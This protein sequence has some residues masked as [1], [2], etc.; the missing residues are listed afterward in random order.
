MNVRTYQ[1]GDEVAQ[2]R[3]YNEAAGAL[4]KFKPASV[5]EVRRR[6]RGAD[7]D[8]ATRFYAIAA[9][10][11]VAYATF[12]GNGRISFPWCLPDHTSLA[13]PLLD[14][15][16]DAMRK[17]GLR[18]AWAAYR[19]DWPAQRD[20]FQARGFA[21]VREMVNYVM[22]IAEMPTPAAR[23]S[24]NIAPL[25]SA[26]L[27][28]VLQLG[29]G[30]LRVGDAAELEKCLF[31]NPYFPPESLFCV[32][33]RVGG[34]PVAVGILVIRAEYANPHQVDAAMPCFRL[35]AFGT[36]NLTHKRIKGLF[37]FLAADTRELSA[38][39]L[40]LLAHA[41]NLVHDV[42]IETFAAQVPSDAPHLN[43]FC[44]SVFRRQGG[45]PIFEREL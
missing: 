40:D 20:F 3:I 10:R 12:Q 36:E 23:T 6:M 30:V 17:S 38:F 45:F 28:V 33:S 13:S 9:G 15:V 5:D 24:S 31:H 25:T 14:H 26:D 43:R 8:P 11:P 19:A 16:L 44:Q 7:F 37:S 29:A 35:G 34:Q 21:Q 42:D 27:P 22:D 41:S 4:P 18:K 2:V 39:A 32:R 1:M